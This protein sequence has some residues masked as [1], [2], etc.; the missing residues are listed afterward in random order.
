MDA[1]RPSASFTCSSE[2]IPSVQQTSRP[3]PL[4]SSTILRILPKAPFLLPSSRH[5][6]PMQKRVEPAAF[7][8]RAASLTAS[9]LMSGSGFTNV[10]YRVDCAQYLQSSLQP[11]VLMERRVQRCTSRG[12][13]CCLWTV[14]AW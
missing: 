10:L 7:A 9:T 12:S 8:R 13:K 1:A 6:V 2:S 3:M 5:A 4:T 14:E 11:P